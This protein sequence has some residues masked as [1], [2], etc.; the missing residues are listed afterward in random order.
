M[1]PS[2]SI[3]LARHLEGM[4]VHI[5]RDGFASWVREDLGFAASDEYVDRALVRVQNMVADGGARS[6]HELTVTIAADM[7]AE[8][9]ID[10][11]GG[12]AWAMDW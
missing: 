9:H 1:G 7:P 12:S 4:G 5:I 2:S 3:D 6:V 8:T 11:F 10:A